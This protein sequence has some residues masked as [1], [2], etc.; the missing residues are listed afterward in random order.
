[1]KIGT[2]SN[3]QSVKKEAFEQLIIRHGRTGAPFIWD[4]SVT[5]GEIEAWRDAERAARQ[6]GRKTQSRV[7]RPD[8]SYYARTTRFIDALDDK[9][10]LTAWRSRMVALGLSADPTIIDEIRSISQN[11]QDAE[12][13]SLMDGYTERAVEAAGGNKNRNYGTEI[14]AI[15]ED[16][17]EG[18]EPN[19]IP[20]EF[21]D[22]VED[23]KAKTAELT[24]VSVEQFCVLDKYKVAGTHD[25]LCYYKRPGEETAR[26]VVADIKAGS[27]DYGQG[28]F[29]LQLGAYAMMQAYDPL[30]NS[31]RPLN[32]MGNEV[33]Q[34]YGLIIHTPAS[35]TDPVAIYEVDIAKGQQGLELCAS[36]S[37][38][39]S[40]WGRKDNKMVQ[41]A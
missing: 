22:M 4:P 21:E 6:A 17:D 2:V 28:K 35:G 29:A 8:G 3:V 25:R 38:W 7:K 40:Y 30:T 9:T 1:M 27:I 16:I 24:F 41:I 19:F 14:H 36:I 18:R 31:R 5:Q 10:N 32:H 39:R 11:E 13:K 37:E 15:F 23:Y 20:F 33:D 34:E 12:W 26:L